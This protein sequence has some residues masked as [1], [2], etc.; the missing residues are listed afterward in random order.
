VL[1][2]F[3]T[4]SYAIPSREE[5][6]LEASTFSLKLGQI[7]GLMGPSGVGKST[8]LKIVSGVDPLGKALVTTPDNRQIPCQEA[9]FGYIPQTPLLLPWKT[10]KQNVS[11]ALRKKSDRETVVEKALDGLGLLPFK[12]L[13]PHEISLGMASRVAFAR[14]LVR[15]A[16]VIFMD[17]PFASW[18]PRLKSQAIHDLSDLV[19]RLNMCVLFATH[20]GY[21][22]MTLAQ[23]IF[24][25]KGRPATLEKL[26]T[27]EKDQDWNPPLSDIFF[28]T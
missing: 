27:L 6:L 17:E 3:V 25:L 16:K 11:L 28:L 2:Y 24:V 20:S 9:G 5:P 18:D 23:D 4:P 26:S 12:N 10:V 1:F 19:H 8:F 15:G 13:Y 14:E 21:E 22:A 7:A